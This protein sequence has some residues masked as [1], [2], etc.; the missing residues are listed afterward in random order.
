MKNIFSFFLGLFFLSAFAQKDTITFN[1]K[2]IIVGE[3]KQMTSNI[4]ILKTS[5]SDKDFNIEFDK[6]SSLTLEHQYSIALSNGLRVYGFIKTT[7]E[8]KV[9]ITQA[10]NQTLEVEF[11]QIVSLR[12]IDDGFWN[13]F[14]GSFDFG[15]VLTKSNNSEQFNFSGVLNYSSTKWIHRAQYNQLSST[16]DDV[17]DIK[18]TDWSVEI[19]RY[20]KRKWFVSSNVSFL[21]NTSQEIEGRLTPNIGA[22]NYLIRNNKLF[23]LA[24]AGL[25][26]N[27]EKYT[28]SDDNKQSTEMS[29][30]TQYS[31][32]NF[33]NIELFF[34]LT[35]YPSLS[36]S[37][38][39]RSDLNFRIKYDMP[40]DFYFKT[41][42]QVNY[43]NQ[44]VALAVKTDYVFS[45]GVGWELK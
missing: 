42:L 7:P 37:G 8:K 33:K 34:A 9:L 36:E 13:H 3:L 40:Y 10:N 29:I 26:Y 5:Y 21:S 23:L 43:D 27:I 4:I 20:L 16:Q 41:E 22:G 45:T 38:R 28:N 1:N 15:Y 17:E 31:M 12:K 39:F 19:K 32:F 18:R 6:V 14:K 2:D 35:G 11:N 30:M 24:G 25:T 44:P